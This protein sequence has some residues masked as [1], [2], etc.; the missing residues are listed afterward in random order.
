MAQVLVLDEDTDSRIL[1]KRLLEL[2]GHSVVS[3]SDQGQAIEA[4]RSGNPD[5]VII[6]LKA[7][8]R[9]SRRLPALLKAGNERLKVMTI[10]DY[11]PDQIADTALGDDFLAK[12]V[13]LETIESKVRELLGRTNTERSAG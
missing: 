9:W 6:H 3:V 12:P 11:V 8:S 5:L 13:D 4:A 2:G 7:G 10:A 1:L